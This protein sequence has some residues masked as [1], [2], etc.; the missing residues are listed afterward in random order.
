MR[1]GQLDRD[2]HRRGER[3]DL[4]QRPAAWQQRDAEGKANGQKLEHDLQRVESGM[5]RPGREHVRAVQLI[6]DRVVI[7]Q[8]E[9]AAGKDEEQRDA[10]SNGKAGNAGG[11]RP[12]GA[13]V[14]RRIE[15]QER[16]P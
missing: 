4:G 12:P 1:R 2:R 14:R 8:A 13:F 11:Q 3:A 7:Q 5:Q 9:P 6:A 16:R 15:R 10:D